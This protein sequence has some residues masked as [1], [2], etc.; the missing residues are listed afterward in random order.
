MALPITIFTATYN[1]C[2]LLQRLYISLKEQT[3]YKF[4][5]I[6][7]DDGSF[8]DTEEAVAKFDTDRFDIFYIKQVHGGKHRAINKGI[9]IARGEYFFIVD[10]DDYLP[11]DSIEK[12][13]NW[14]SNLRNNNLAGVAGL[15]VL[16]DGTICGGR[17]NLRDGEWIEATN[18]ERKRLGLMGDKAEIYKTSIMRRH[19]FPEFEGEYFVTESVCWDAIAAEGKKIRWYN[20]SIYIADYQPTGLTQSG[21]N[22]LVGH[23]D[24]FQGYCYYIR[25]SLKIKP[26][27]EGITN[28]REY[29]KTCRYMRIKFL[30]RGK[31]IKFS[32]IS[33]LIWFFVKM[34]VWYMV[35]IIK[36]K[37]LA[38]S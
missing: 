36:Y 22:E 18:F 38:K 10:S 34:P 27:V 8:D 29:N 21:I 5:W 26:I 14:I 1:R 7:I 25:Q 2:Q 11:K 32:V 16:P 23:K 37:I 28:F 9:D 20:E 30:N 13:N 19:P 12:A 6:I 35:R 17:P 31:N 3:S 24:N 4:E 33:Y 15:K